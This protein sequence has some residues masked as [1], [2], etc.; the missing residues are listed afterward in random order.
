MIRIIAT[1]LFSLALSQASFSQTDSAA[2][3][4]IRHGISV[5]AFVSGVPGYP[6]Y[7]VSYSISKGRNRVSIGPVLGEKGGGYL[8]YS[9]G[10]NISL[11]NTSFFKGLSGVYQFF[12]NPS[13]KRYDLFFQ[14]EATW[15]YFNYDGINTGSA[16][17]ITIPNYSSC[18]YVGQ[19]VGYGLRVR[20]LKNCEITHIIGLGNLTGRY[21]VKGMKSSS[22]GDLLSGNTRLSLSYTFR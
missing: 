4:K 17:W 5:G 1:V 16:N 7:L 8:G 11:Q 22:I 3:N 10:T 12:P 15:Q 9:G 14:Y 18:W 20:F 2:A 21:T 19:Y 13:G 6:Y